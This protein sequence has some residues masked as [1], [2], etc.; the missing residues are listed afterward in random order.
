MIE[1]VSHN[2]TFGY[3]TDYRKIGNWTIIDEVFVTE[4]GF[5]RSGVTIADVSGYRKVPV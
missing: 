4:R 1:K 2:N 3:F 5:L